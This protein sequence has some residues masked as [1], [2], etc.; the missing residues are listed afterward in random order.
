MT[1]IFIQFHT[2]SKNFDNIFPFTF[3]NNLDY[4]F[5][6][7]KPQYEQA[8]VI[9]APLSSKCKPGKS[10]L[11][12]QRAEA[13]G[14]AQ[15]ELRVELH[16]AEEHPRGPAHR[17]QFD[18]CHVPET[19]RGVLGRLHQLRPQQKAAVEKLHVQ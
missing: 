17:R 19:V 5:E 14:Q 6:S 8:A 3:T 9:G 4:Y 15:R 7:F 12:L 11:V 1:D 10:R 13:P 2:H 18:Q 16:F